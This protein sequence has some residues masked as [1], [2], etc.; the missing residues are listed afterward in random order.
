[1]GEPLDGEAPA[2][3]TGEPLPGRPVDAPEACDEPLVVWSPLDPDEASP[4]T[5][6]PVDAP[7]DT[8]PL[9]SGAPALSLLS[10]VSVPTSPPE[11]P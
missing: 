11:Q 10:A 4:P 2:L 9:G 7:V 8:E 1:M 3:P 5:V 6:E